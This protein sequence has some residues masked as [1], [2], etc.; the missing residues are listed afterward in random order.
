MSSF[1]Y[2][3]DAIKDFE[4]SISDQVGTFIEN[5]QGHTS[6]LRDLENMHHQ[7]LEEIAMVT[8]EK[9]VKNELDEDIPEDLRDV[10]HNIVYDVIN[11]SMMS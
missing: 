4:R 5:V 1:S 6:G 8:L 7:K 10:S 2:I 3:Q 11:G 9:V